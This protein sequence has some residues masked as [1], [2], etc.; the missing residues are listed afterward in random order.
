MGMDAYK[1]ILQAYADLVIAEDAKN[2]REGLETVSTHAEKLRVQVTQAAEEYY[3]ASINGYKAI[4]EALNFQMPEVPKENL[5]I[6]EN[7]QAFKDAIS[8]GKQIAEILGYSYETMTCFYTALLPFFEKEEYQK[9]RDGL[10]FL[11]TIC[12]QVPEYWIS[13]GIAETKLSHYEEAE[14]AFSSCLEL[15]PF[16]Q[17]A[18][19]GLLYLYT[20][21]QKR[22][23]SIALCND[24]IS[25]AQ[26]HPENERA[27]ELEKMLC[28]IREGI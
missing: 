24:G 25:L 2:F 13:L 27:I 19:K 5:K 12:P 3:Q 22:E 6:L 4:C 21:L 7:Q 15:D 28:K 9:A 8:E 17:D 10:F 26:S 16:S 11:I 20:L 23:E 1:S 18:Y 14:K